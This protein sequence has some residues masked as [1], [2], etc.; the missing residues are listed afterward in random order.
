MNLNLSSWSPPLL[1][2]TTGPVSIGRL[3]SRPRDSARSAACR[4]RPPRNPSATRGSS[5]GEAVASRGESGDA[6][7][8]SREYP[9]KS[10]QQA[11]EC[12]GDN[13]ESSFL[14]TV[15]D[16]PSGWYQQQRGNKLG[17]G[18][19]A[20]GCAAPGE[21]G[22]LTTLE[23][24]TQRRQRGPDDWRGRRNGSPVKTIHRVSMDFIP[25]IA[26]SPR[27]SLHSCSCIAAGRCNSKMALIASG[28]T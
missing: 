25:M 3:A 22:K 13:D 23:A 26:R 6:T 9:Q 4:F 1:W 2:R 12:L 14:E 24:A 19:D 17:G 8:Q 18:H 10:C 28:P 27:V 16:Y 15:S 7:D 5:S 11:G 21:V 20:K